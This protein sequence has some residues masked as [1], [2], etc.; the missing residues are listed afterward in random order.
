MCTGYARCHGD[1]PDAA[2][3]RAGNST[4]LTNLPETAWPCRA[5]A[6]A[7][8]RIGPLVQVGGFNLAPASSLEGRLAV[9]QPR[10]E[11]MT[12]ETE[13]SREQHSV[14]RNVGRNSP[15]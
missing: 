9:W 5:R 11:P 8:N 10:E 1:D 14:G 13:E 3:M 12:S 6:M 2:M 15:N 7:R 4:Y